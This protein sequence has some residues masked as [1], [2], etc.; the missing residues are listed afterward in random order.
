MGGALPPGA[1][2]AWASKVEVVSVVLVPGASLTRASECDGEG[3]CVG[4]GV[5]VDM[6]EALAPCDRLGGGVP[7]GVGEAVSL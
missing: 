1:R 4:V 3:K 7:E 5:C 6:A 2:L